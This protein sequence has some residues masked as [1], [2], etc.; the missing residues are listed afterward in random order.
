MEASRR[1]LPNETPHNQLER[2]WYDIDEW[3]AWHEGKTDYD[4]C[5][6][7]TI[8][9]QGDGV[10]QNVHLGKQPLRSDGLWLCSPDRQPFHLQLAELRFHDG[11]WWTKL[12][13]A[14]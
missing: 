13:K 11:W 2:P 10:L 4:G 1:Y 8:R 14:G 12:E 6:N 3:L 9:M 7:G 5:W